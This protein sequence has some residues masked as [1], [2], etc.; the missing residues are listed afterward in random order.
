MYVR[1]CMC[2][3]SNSVVVECWSGSML[4]GNQLPAWSFTHIAL[5]VQW[6]RY[7]SCEACRFQAEQLLIVVNLVLLLSMWYEQLS[8]KLIIQSSTVF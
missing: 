7:S 1:M 5:V 2:C 3:G 8:F 6:E 4:N